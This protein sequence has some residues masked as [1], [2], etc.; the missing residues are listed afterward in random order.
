MKYRDLLLALTTAD[1]TAVIDGR[2]R[3]ARRAKEADFNHGFTRM[4]R[5]QRQEM[6]RFTFSLPPPRRVDVSR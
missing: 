1:G 3:M 2:Y 4:D 5:A 6:P